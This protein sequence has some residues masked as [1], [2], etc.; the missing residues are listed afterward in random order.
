M[1]Q[2]EKGTPEGKASG[3][4]LAL[5]TGDSLLPRFRLSDQQFPGGNSFPHEALS[6]PCLTGIR[7]TA[8]GDRDAPNSR[9][10]SAQEIACSG[11][12]VG[13]G[14]W[15]TEAK[16]GLGVGGVKIPGPLLS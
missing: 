9:P 2:A 11:P 8:A 4:E 5:A 3:W 14:A 7:N 10:H 13:V 16:R 12:R 15:G 6:C 1:E